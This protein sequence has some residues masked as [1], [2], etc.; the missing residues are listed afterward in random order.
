MVSTDWS[1]GLQNEGYVCWFTGLTA[2]CTL[3]HCVMVVCVCAL[4]MVIGGTNINRERSGLTSSRCDLLIATPG[5][6][7]DH[8]DSTP[9]FAGRLWGVQV[10]CSS[11]RSRKRLFGA[12]RLVPILS[13][14]MPFLWLVSVPGKLGNFPGTQCH[15]M[16][17]ASPRHFLLFSSQP[18]DL[19]H[20]ALLLTPLACNAHAGVGDG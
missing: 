5:R 18:V 4:Q 9:G 1:L 20:A 2:Q 8:L 6:L 14:R 13:A 15:L 7:T 11:K 3:V 17:S 10:R 12:L 16:I 19:A